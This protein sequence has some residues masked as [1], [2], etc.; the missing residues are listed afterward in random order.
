MKYNF[1]SMLS[2][3]LVC[4]AVGM[5]AINMPMAKAADIEQLTL[6]LPSIV[7]DPVPGTEVDVPVTVVDGYTDADMV[8]I[9]TIAIEYDSS[10]VEPKG[11]TGDGLVVDFETFG[12]T[13]WTVT[14]NITEDPGTLPNAKQLR[15]LINNPLPGIFPS[16]SEPTGGFPADLLTIKFIVQTDNPG[17]STDLLFVDDTYFRKRDFDRLLLDGDTVNGSISF[18]DTQ[19]ATFR[20]VEDPPSPPDHGIGGHFFVEF[21]VD[22]AAAHPGDLLK[23]IE[24]YVQFTGGTIEVANPDE[25]FSDIPSGFMVLINDMD[26]DDRLWLTMVQPVMGLPAEDD[27]LMAK[28]EFIQ[29]QVGSSHLEYLTE[30]PPANGTRYSLGSDPFTSIIP[31]VVP[32]DVCLPDGK[33]TLVCKTD[34]PTY[35][36]WERVQVLANVDNPGD[37]FSA[38]LL[39]GIIVVRTPPKKSFILTGQAVT[40]TIDPGLNPDIFLYASPPIITAIAPKV[41]HGAFCVLYT[42]EDGI[43]AIDTCTW[44]LTTPPDAAQEKF[45][46]DLIRSYIDRYGLENLQNA[47]AGDLL[48]APATDAPS[49][50]ALGRAFPNTANPE[51]WFPFQLAEPSEV[52]IKIYNA[53]GQL[54]KTLDL[55][56]QE[57]GYYLNREKA[58]F[59]DGR[60]ERGERIAS[61]IYFYTM[62]TEDFTATG[63][64]VISK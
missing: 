30:P 33:L 60:N 26:G 28:V 20:M 35:N 16:L 5:L 44:G 39:G 57:A 62:L 58:A 21:R 42:E 15:I 46:L 22:A 50:T 64:V 56:Y 41:T 51:T 9:I 45:F 29:T 2:A 59:W 52:T 63:K 19:V 48:P 43:L 61:G 7:T 55:G 49:Q 40:K 3:L 37:S 14:A 24:L 36:P 11:V 10:V 27:I 18:T 31:I 34:K 53:S 54:V 1:H 32:I 23:T 6:E 47:N 13:G 8:E 38:N 4:L 25:P 17:D 12:I